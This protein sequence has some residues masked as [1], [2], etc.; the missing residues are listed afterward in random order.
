MIND[1]DI[2]AGLSLCGVLPFLLVAFCFWRMVRNIAERNLMTARDRA[3]AVSIYAAI[4]GL[5]AAGYV[6]GGLGLIA[7]TMARHGFEAE[8]LG[9]AASGLVGVLVALSTIP[10][11]V[12]IGQL[13]RLDS[14]TQDQ[15]EIEIDS[16]T[17]WLELFGWLSVFVAAL[18]TAVMLGFALIPFA[19]VI[20]LAVPTVVWYQR[21]NQ[22]AQLLWLLAL[23]IRQNRDLGQEVV[24]QAKGWPGFY[25]KRLR[26]LA[27]HLQAGRSLATSLILCRP[28]PIPLSRWFLGAVFCLFTF[29]FGL[30]IVFL[31]LVFRRQ[32]IV[33]AWCLTSIRTAEENGTLDVALAEC[34]TQHLTW[35]KDRFRAGSLS[36]MIFYLCGY[37]FAVSLIVAFLLYAIVPK[38]K[39]IFEGFGVELPELTKHMIAFADLMVML[40]SGP[41]LVVV[42]AMPLAMLLM[43]LADHQGWR[44]LRLR[45]FA[46]IY[47]RFDSSEILRHLSYTIERQ[48]P[49]TEGLLAI[50][51]NHHRPVIAENFAEIVSRVESGTR[52]WTLLRAWGFI[53]KRDLAVLESAERSGNL[54][55]ALR[56]VA[57]SRERKLQYRLDVLLIMLRPVC[58]VAMGILVGFIATSMFLPIVK[59]LNDLS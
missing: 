38:F 8:I 30:I 26:E 42:P 27:A 56:E 20:L 54:P 12:V 19:M 36:G 21:R 14:D 33:P 52:C 59:L 9:G 22:E 32:G 1:V 15:L 13:N 6:L 25:G 4:V 5:V 58:I 44:N 51:N 10:A 11:F 37:L 43:L 50:A 40:F 28:D 46:P 7:A 31:L 55:W 17:G 45:V 16:S 48:Q 29:G 39:R 57:R 24:A 49:L 41:L 3:R 18:V 34:A 2:L 23:A 53:N 35:L 47:R